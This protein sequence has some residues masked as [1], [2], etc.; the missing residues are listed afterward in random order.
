MKPLSVAAPENLEHDDQARL[1]QLA[2]RS[3]KWSILYNTLPRLVTPFSTILLAALLTPSDFG[4]VAISTFIIAFAR[5]LVD[6]GLGKAVIQR[7]TFVNE[8]ASISLWTSLLLAAGLYLLLWFAAPWLSVLYNNSGVTSVI[9]VSGC[10][11]LIYASMTAPNALLRRKMEFRYLFWVETSLLVIQAVASVILALGGLGFWAIILGQ[12]MGLTLSAILAWGLVRWRPLF[13]MD[14]ALLYSM[15]GFSLWVMVAGFQSWLFLYADKAIAGAFFQVDT[16]GVYS[17]GFNFAILIP[18]FLAASLTDVAYPVFCKLQESSRGVGLNLIRL[19]TLAGAVLF[20]MAFGL[21]AVA[22]PMIQLLYGDKWQ[23]L[24][25]VISILAILPGLVPLWSLNES[26]YQA[27]GRPDVWTKLAGIS[28][29]CLLP[30]LLISASYGILVFVIARFLGAL[31]LPI[32]NFFVGA[33]ILGIGVKDQLKSIGFPLCC[34]MIMYMSVVMLELQMR[35]FEG[36]TGWVKL[37]FSVAMGAGIY[38]SLV[39][40]FNRDLWRGLL[41][42]AQRVLSKGQA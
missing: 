37:M 12:L 3:V 42:S 21:S 32:G 27:I 40:I 2:A 36:I 25:M 16:L 20:P 17:L 19:Q 13:L 31:I 6:L 24:G 4:L 23:G 11:L 1:I 39:W 38:V 10:S 34:S 30:L 28:L 22:S 29:L 14:R 18:T 15:L 9:R 8:S 5:I 26:A 41:V 35:P 33:R 7:Q